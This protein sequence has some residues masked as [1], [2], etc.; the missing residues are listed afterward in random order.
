MAKVSVAIADDTVMVCTPPA[1]VDGSRLAGAGNSTEADE[2][3][4][5]ARA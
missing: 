4:H 3:D 2:N 1:S 5:R